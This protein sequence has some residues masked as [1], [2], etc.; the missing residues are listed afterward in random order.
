MCGICGFTSNIDNRKNILNSM[1]LPL[2]SRGPDAE[3]FYM[4]NEIALGH[5]RLSILDL[6]TRANQPFHDNEMGL[7]LVYNGEIYNFKELK[8]ELIEKFNC[9]FLTTS[10]TEVVLKSFKYWGTDCFLKFDGMF[11]LGIWDE[12]KKQLTLA[13]DKFG[14][15]PL[16]YNEF[17][18]GN[19]KEISFSSELNSLKYG[20]K[21]NKKLNKKSIKS[22]LINN[23]ANSLETFYVDSHQMEP[24]TFLVFK[25]NAIKIKKYFLIDKYFNK[26]KN[27]K[28]FDPI[29]LD[30]IISKTVKSRM[31]SDVKLGVF[32]SGGLDSSI[33]S[34]YAKN[35]DKNI[36]SFT[37]GFEE[38][39][40]DESSKSKLV[41][42]HLGIKNINFTLE[43]KDLLE[44]ENIVLSFGQPLSDTSIIPTYYLSKFT[45]EHVKV[46][47]SGDGGDE[48]FFGYDTYLASNLYEIL[49]KGNFNTVLKYLNYVIS[50]FPDNKNKINLIFQIKKF[51]SSFNEKKK[52]FSSHEFWR[53]INNNLSLKK[54]LKNDF[55][56]EIE[57]L[58]CSVFTFDKSNLINSKANNNLYDFQSFLHNDILVKTDR[59]SMAHS[60]EVR[61]PFLSVDII[62]YLKDLDPKVRFNCLNRKQALK[63]VSK[64][65]LPPDTINQKKRGFNSPV[66]QWLNTIFYDIFMDNL[67]TQKASNLFNVSYI[68]KILINNKKK[69]IDNGNVL[70]NI[71]CLLIWVNNNDCII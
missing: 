31:I 25:N 45:K 36:L 70:F 60:L 5:K 48:L 62:E 53:T 64:Y 42:D 32:L 69:N 1:M 68:E 39:S 54:I 34:H 14:E 37:L 67:K 17:K 23:Y 55:F 28:R 59:A 11:A 21:F 7:S 63:S 2:H 27:Y 29:E 56:L 26:R 33:I 4:K 9:K 8:N 49:D 71:L 10:D 43:K 15:K 61:S 66:S 44:I 47:L 20:P 12:P 18:N 52:N 30:S 40:Y 35:V 46:C 3:G 19:K 50:F 41:S 58:D 22:Y 6:N 51:L 16:Y 38:K 24:G 57:N 13:R 65:I